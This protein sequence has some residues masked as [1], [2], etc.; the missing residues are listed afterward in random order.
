MR[1]YTPPP[2]SIDWAANRQA[3]AWAWC[4]SGLVH[5]LCLGLIAVGIESLPDGWGTL[6]ET[7]AP[8][9]SELTERSIDLWHHDRPSSASDEGNMLGHS[10]EPAVR[11]DGKSSNRSLPPEF[12]ETEVGAVGDPIDLGHVFDALR[13]VPRPADEV[14]IVPL[15]GWW[16]TG[17]QGERPDRGLSRSAGKDYGSV[18]LFGLE[19]AGQRVVYVIDRS[20]S[21]NDQGGR[22]LAAV[23]TELIKSLQSLT[24]GQ[25][26][27]LILYNQRPQLYSLGTTSEPSGGGQLLNG[28]TETI[29]RVIRYVRGARAFGDTDHLAALRA[30][31]WLA[32]DLVF[33]LTDGR[34]PAL[35]ER[36]L[37]EV[38]RLAGRAGAVVHAIEFG[39]G[40]VAP[41][42]TFVRTLARQNGGEYRYFSV[43]D[44]SS[45][46][47]P[48]AEEVRAGEVEGVGSPN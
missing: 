14:G 19:G 42:E 10:L 24:P 11:F 4:L 34:W 40:A 1:S 45:P 3:S 5:G 18:T 9:R 48:L 46:A 16:Q 25:S 20:D 41:D 37:A 2:P 38:R 23:K 6:R 36:D 21:M 26:F 35:S 12:D 15:E 17:T 33:F 39:S 13:A 30:A 22:P 8:Q 47:S 43:Q 31:L 27:Q 29:E 44:V 7:P 32:P 28:D